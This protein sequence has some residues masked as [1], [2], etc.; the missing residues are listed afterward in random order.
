MNNIK[1]SIIIPVYNVK[2]YL[3]RCLD[4]VKAQMQEEVEVII[5]DDASTDGSTEIL[6]EYFDN[7]RWEFYR[8][9]KNRGLSFARNEGMAHAHGEYVTF[10]D[11]DDKYCDSAVQTMLDAIKLNKDIVQF[12]QIRY[13]EPINVY[14]IKYP[15]QRGSYDL[16]NRPELWGFATNKIYRMDFL[17]EKH[18]SFK[19]G[20]RFGED[21]PFVLKCLLED[22]T[23]YHVKGATMIRYFDN[24]NSICHTT[25]PKE[26]HEQDEYYVDIY[27]SLRFK[28]YPE[29]KYKE[30]EKIIRERRSHGIYQNIGLP[31]KEVI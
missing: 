26:V 23:F 4:S 12:Q 9:D 22:A 30:V 13:Y 8:S 20:L 21:E 31:K 16:W 11:S 10:L 6:K 15:N 25:T 17:R 1:L 2:D 27:W 5:Y 19:E 24:K 3:R 7:E 18:I 14:K 28:G 29:K